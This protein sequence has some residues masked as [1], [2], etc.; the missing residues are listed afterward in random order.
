MSPALGLQEQ[1]HLSLICL[2]ACTPA[3]ELPGSKRKAPRAIEDTIWPAHRALCG[4][5]HKLGRECLRTEVKDV[6]IRVIHQVEFIT[7]SLLW[8]RAAEAKNCVSQCQNTCTPVT[9]AP[10]GLSQSRAVPGLPRPSDP[11]CPSVSPVVPK[12]IT[13][14]APHR[15][16]R[17]A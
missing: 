4:V 2:K 6:E 15:A 13:L 8:R 17:P 14:P 5:R 1:L 3:R 10:K 7:H 12:V 11:S 16:G 9:W